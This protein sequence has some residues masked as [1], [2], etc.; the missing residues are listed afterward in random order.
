MSTNPKAIIIGSGIGGMATAVRL[1][2]QGFDVE[3]F[4]KNSYPGGKLYAFEK[5]GFHFDAGPSLFT[6]P[7]NIEALFELAAEPAEK[8]F[9]YR[10]VDIA[11]KYFYENGKVLQ[12]YTDTTAFATELHKQLHEAPGAV[13]GYLRRAATLYDNIG[14][15]FLDYSLHKRETWLHKRIFKALSAVRLAY[16]FSSLH[17]YNR[18]KFSAPETVQLFNRFATYN[19]SNPYKAPAMLSMI[20]HLEQNQGAFYPD[21]GMISI[22]K[23]VYQ[24]A[25]A[26]GVK[27]Y[28]NESVQQILTS[29]GKVQG[30]LVGNKIKPAAIVVSNADVYVTYQQL[31]QNN[32]KAKKILKQERSSSAV[33]FYWGINKIF[34]QLHLHNIFFSKDYKAEFDSIFNH[35]VVC[36]DPTVYVNI[37]SKMEPAQAPAGME[38]WVVMG[39]APADTGHNWQALKEKLRNIIIEKLE[40]I[41]KTDLRSCIVTEHT[42]DP[43]M[44]AQQTA[45]QNGALY[46]SSS[47]SAFAA[48]LRQPNFSSATRGLY[49]CGGSVHPGGGIPLCLKSAKIV[50]ELIAADFN[51]QQP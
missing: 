19:G 37:T 6:Q 8:Y 2:V 24:L 50:S 13:T 25:L 42:L 17:Q 49:F 44:I 28:F 5:D 7:Q 1:A 46:G 21:G 18:K 33:I 4:E 47:N 16:L 31:L 15:V 43:L 40:R 20:P 35:K 34:P 14:T 9:T 10:P 48:F 26:K 12:A 22:T 38:N 29:A 39:N 41:L 51:R 27:F 30:V 45:A 3:V 32:K 36:A 23:A 11:C